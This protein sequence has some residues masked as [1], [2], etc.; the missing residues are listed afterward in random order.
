M[1]FKFIVNHPM[2]IDVFLCIRELDECGYIRYQ[3]S[4]HPKFGSGFTS[5]VGKYSSITVCQ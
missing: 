5:L 1:Q 4:Y 2:L 3:P